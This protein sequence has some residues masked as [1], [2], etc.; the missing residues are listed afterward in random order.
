[1][2]RPIIYKQGVLRLLDQRYLPLQQNYCECKSVDDVA[3]AIKKMKVRGAPAIG[4]AAA[5]G[6][7]FG[8]IN[9]LDADLAY[10][11]LLHTRPTAVNLKWALNRMMVSLQKY[12]K[13]H[14]EESAK[15][16][17]DE[18]I[19]TNQTLGLQGSEFCKDKN[20]IL[21]HCNAGALA[22]AGYGTALG[23]IRSL[24]D[25][26]KDIHVYVDE[27]R[28]F[29]QGSRLTS[30]ELREEGISHTVICDNMAGFLMGREMVD[31]VIVGADRIASNG[32][33]ANKIGTYQL[34]VL[35][36]YH[37]IPF[38]VAA[39]VSTFDFSLNNGED[40]PIEYR[41]K[42]EVAYCGHDRV[43]PEGVDILNPAFDVTPHNLISAFITE[44][45]VF[46]SE[47]IKKIKGG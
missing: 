16:I 26:N 37:N 17:F 32:D 28:P 8:I 19:R 36:D 14:L 13:E 38:Y 34:A 4:V 21:T 2:L 45:G 42:N 35:A 29:F 7:Y 44:K 6:F 1:M 24:F 46:K 39:P 43:V 31:A 23:V 5:F 33:T 47:G 22:T 40:I 25:K 10:K 11:S 15:E 41:E 20:K 27:T 12:G 30:F 3:E 9:G 18:D